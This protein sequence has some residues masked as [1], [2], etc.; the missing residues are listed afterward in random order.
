MMAI[1]AREATQDSRCRTPVD[2]YLIKIL[3]ALI[4]MFKTSLY[5]PFQTAIVAA[6]TMPT[7][8]PLYP[9]Y[10][11]LGSIGMAIFVVFAVILNIF[12]VPMSPFDGHSL[13]CMETYPDIV[14][15]GFK[16]VI[17]FFFCC[18][19]SFKTGSRYIITISVLMILWCF[20]ITR[21]H[22]PYHR[23]IRVIY[24]NTVVSSLW[25]ALCAIIQSFVRLESEGIFYLLIGM[26]LAVFCWRFVLTYTH[27][28]RLA[29]WKN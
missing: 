5:I 12:Y 11:A 14:K 4:I 23:V 24:T 16:F 2:R 29:T 7:D 18:D 17:P 3:N 20:A 21:M 26:P 15:N 19:S 9:A 6:L 8:S 22:Q 28:G 13:A 10:I 25:V 27:K 1:G